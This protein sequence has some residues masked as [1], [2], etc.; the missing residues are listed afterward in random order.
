MTTDSLLIREHSGNHGARSCGVFGKRT[1]RSVAGNTEGP[2]LLSQTC[3]I[4]QSYVSRA[5]SFEVEAGE[6][7]EECTRWGTREGK[8]G[9]R[10]KDETGSFRKQGPFS[11]R[12]VVKRRSLY[13]QAEGEVHAGPR[14]DPVVHGV[15]CA[16][17]TEKG[18][19]RGEFRV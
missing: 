3:R 15:L 5:D 7:L 14:L 16:L 4:Q 10:K 18:Q 6:V 1:S 19:E 2:G 12:K 13:R 11:D 9:I 17:G 8:T